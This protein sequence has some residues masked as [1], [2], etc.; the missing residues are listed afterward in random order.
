MSLAQTPAAPG[1]PMPK[2]GAP[3]RRGDRW[4][5]AWT[6]ADN[7]RRF[8]T[9]R[10]K[11]EAAA[12]QAR[13]KTETAAI[14]SGA[15]ARPPAAHTFN[16]LADYWMEHRASRKRSEKDDRSIIEAHLRPHFG[17]MQVTK[18]DVRA[19]DAFRR[20]VAEVEPGKK[21]LSDKTI[22]NHLTLLISMLNMAVELH[23]LTSAP[24]IKKPK[25]VEGDYAWIR[26]ASDIHRFLEAAREENP[27]IFE[28]YATAIFSGLRAGELLGL[29]WDD[30]EFSGE[31][32]LITVKRS[33]DKPTKTGAIRHVP[34]MDALKPVL[35]EWRARTPGTWVF[36]GRTGNMQSPSA[37]VLQETFQ[38]VVERA[39]IATSGER[40]TFHDL[41][42]TFASH[43]VMRG[44][45]LYKLQKVLGHKSVQMTQR[46]AHLTPEAFNGLR[47]LLP[48]AVPGVGAGGDVVAMGGRR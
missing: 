36:P 33:Y 35:R 27:G 28:L 11:A 7:E 42:H 26:G 19:V 29:R 3:Y 46:Y 1:A 6:D 30:I 21:P 2:I 20:R 24:R 48:G 41:R 32:P 47:G 34:L 14:K 17:K 15:L 25:L 10:T 38:R 23:W 44:W 18:L 22:H 16:E 9:F 8:A 31:N 5:I 13:L 39:G 12:E 40:L 37:R 4:R 43:W 45:D